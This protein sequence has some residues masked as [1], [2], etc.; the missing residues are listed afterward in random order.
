MVVTFD[1]MVLS[2][3]CACAV[4]QYKRRLPRFYYSL[5]VCFGSVLFCVIWGAI[6][7]HLVGSS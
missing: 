2:I 4:H 3:L 5:A 6:S 1:L 7:T